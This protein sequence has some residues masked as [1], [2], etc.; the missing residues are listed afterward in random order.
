M[1]MYF[2]YFYDTKCS[3]CMTHKCTESCR[4]N[5]P[6]IQ[7]IHKLEAMESKRNLELLPTEMQIKIMKELEAL[8]LCRLS[9]VSRALKQ[10]LEE[11]EN[12][13]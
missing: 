11:N 8:D 9:S 5:P 3:E 12:V 13:L 2:P 6:L 4:F 10:L 7:S 1:E